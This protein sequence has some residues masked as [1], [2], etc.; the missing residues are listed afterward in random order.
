MENKA[1][2]I[3]TTIRGAGFFGPPGIRAHGLLLPGDPL[4]A[5]REPDNPVDSNAIV[6]ATTDDICIGYVAR[7][8][9]AI[10]APWMDR[11]WVYTAKC[12]RAAKIQ[13][14]RRFRYVI[15]ETLPVR[16]T[17]IPPATKTTDISTFTSLLNSKVL[18]DIE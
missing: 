5:T 3:E 6:V 15:K 11:G 12:V 17:P 16:L 2:T 10:L 7:E 1:P 9:A 13:S 4:I 18:E 14:R 8:N